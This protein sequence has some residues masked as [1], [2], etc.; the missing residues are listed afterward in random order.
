MAEP[1]VSGGV[2]GFFFASVAWMLGWLVA[3][4]LSMVRRV[5]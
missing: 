1:I 4:F 3:Q 2:V 5:R